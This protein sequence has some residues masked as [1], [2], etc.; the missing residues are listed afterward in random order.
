MAVTEL[1]HI[2]QQNQAVGFGR[3]V[4]QRR[5]R[6]GA[7]QDVHLGARTQMQVGDDQRAGQL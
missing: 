1:H 6:L 2:A 3:R 5:P 7:S 4:E